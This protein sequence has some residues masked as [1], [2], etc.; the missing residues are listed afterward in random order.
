[1][2]RSLGRVLRFLVEITVYHH[3]MKVVCHC[4]NF[5]IT[6]QNFLFYHLSVFP[7]FMHIKVK[8]SP[9][10]ETRDL[11][12][13]LGSQPTDDRSHKPGSRLPGPRLPPQLP[14]IT[15]HWLIPNYTT[16]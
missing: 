11:L 1:M 10:L 14:T 3:C 2:N 13:V 7:H 9:V 4:H 12:L 8:G 16:L 6:S 15:T 5:V